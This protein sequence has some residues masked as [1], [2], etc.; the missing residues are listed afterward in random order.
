MKQYPK[1]S[2]PVKVGR[3]NTGAEDVEPQLKVLR[4]RV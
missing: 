1:I 3:P 2:T 4:K